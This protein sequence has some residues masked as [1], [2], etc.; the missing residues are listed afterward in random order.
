MESPGHVTLAEMPFD[1]VTHITAL[2]PDM[3]SPE[4]V[5][6]LGSMGFLPGETV[7][8]IHG[9][10]LGK[11]DPLAIRIGR[12]TIALRRRYAAAILVGVPISGTT[13]S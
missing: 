4:E 3:L 10:G 2:M 5:R 7:T 12:T 1:I 11:I 9:G 6:R 8:K 13:G